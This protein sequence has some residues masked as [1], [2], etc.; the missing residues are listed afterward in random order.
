VSRCILITRPAADALPFADAL[1]AAGVATMIEPMMTIEALP[2][3]ALDL[4]GV[5][6][7][8]AT[9]ANG[10]RALAARTE[11]RDVP[12]YAVGDA[13]A[14]AAE[15]LGFTPVTRA[16]GDVTALAACVIAR[17]D[18][19]EGRCCMPPARRWPAIWAVPWP[20]PASAIGANASMPRG[21]WRRCRRRR[22]AA[23]AAGRIDGVA[24]F[25]PRTARIFVDRVAAAGCT[26][27]LARVDAFCLS[28]AVGDAAAGAPW[29]RT[30]VAGEPTGRALRALVVDAVQ[31]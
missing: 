18:P 16:A 30:F 6:A 19:A 14:R 2:G 12:L 17:C 15:A 20:P 7:I 23:L 5:Q 11:R 26:T 8:L 25:S 9:S 27:S 29:R 3:P 4:A 13:T 31:A 10:A 1:A 21:R 24:L 22:G 28:A